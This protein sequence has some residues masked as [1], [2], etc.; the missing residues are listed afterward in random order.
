MTGMMNRFQSSGSSAVSSL[1][2][3]LQSLA[4]KVIHVGGLMAAWAGAGAGAGILGVAGY[5]VHLNDQLEKTRISLGAIFSAQ[6]FASNLQQGLGMASDQIARMR[7]DAALLPGEFTDLVGI[8]QAISIPGAQAGL[9][10]DTIRT[11]AS[12]VMAAGAVSNLPM[13]Q[14]AREAAMLM[15]GRSGA[16]NV[17]GMRLMGLSG[18]A[19]EK[20][21]K[22]APDKRVALMAR[23]LDKYAP[24][25]DEFGKSFEGVSSTFRDNVKTFAMLAGS[26]LFEKLK[27]TF[28]AAN[29]WFDQ[30]KALITT[31]G[32]AV[33]D[34]LG[35]AF[36]I[37]VSKIREWWPVIR[38]F[39]TNAY[40]RLVDI[41]TTVQPYVETF[42]SA[43]Q[44]ALRD[45][46]TIDKLIL[47]AKIW[48]GIKIGGALVG[49]VS[50]AMQLGGALAGKAS[51]IGGMAAGAWAATTE[52]AGSAF[53]ALTSGATVAG[54]TFVGLSGAVLTLGAGLAA[55]GGA[56]FA[57]YEAWKLFGEGSQ[58]IAADDRA[59]HDMA[60]RLMTSSENLDTAYANTMSALDEYRSANNEAAASA[61]EFAM[62]ASALGARLETYSIAAK[63]EERDIQPTLDRAN[64]MFLQGARDAMDPSKAAQKT[65]LH[66][67]GGGGT[68]VQKVEIVVT[69]NQEPSRIARSVAIEFANRFRRP[70]SSPDVAHYGRP[71]T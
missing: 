36:D 63:R 41:W 12:K 50:G 19:A 54:T 45:P 16:H 25:I 5:T 58:V 18:D 29:E 10:V 42:G 4:A 21:N 31:W 38:D 26:P 15:S 23:E 46:G 34:K 11:L 68:H 48:A 20:F 53:A 56:V 51:T 9:G 57:G 8:F 35:R 2:G 27:H 55:L 66:P 3:G 52:A 64:L 28:A 30:N 44:T 17:L 24:A 43:L 70:G 69:S 59:R 1:T 47:L 67:G 40:S 6:G 60:V 61:I 39:T 32:A 65:P 22:M 62:A 37:G 33:G 13:D 14:V 71:G 7:K 49:G